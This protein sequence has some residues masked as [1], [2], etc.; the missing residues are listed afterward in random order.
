MLVG[1]VIY[2]RPRTHGYV[3]AM[4]RRNFLKCLAGLPALALFPWREQWSYRGVV[5]TVER[6]PED[7]AMSFAGPSGHTG[8]R[9]RNRVAGSSESVQRKIIRRAIDWQLGYRPYL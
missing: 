6:G 9:M 4:K 8:V 2:A 1:S 7:V 3:D 5:I